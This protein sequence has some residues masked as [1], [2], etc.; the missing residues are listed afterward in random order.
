[1]P[2][3]EQPRGSV[4]LVLIPQGITLIPSGS[5]NLSKEAILLWVDAGIGAIW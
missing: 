5:E 1:V 3:L 4:W 2:E